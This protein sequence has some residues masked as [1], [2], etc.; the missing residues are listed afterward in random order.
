MTTCMNDMFV[1]VPLADNNCSLSDGSGREDTPASECPLQ[2]GSGPTCVVADTPPTALLQLA[3][4]ATH[5]QS[6]SGPVSEREKET[7]VWLCMI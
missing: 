6:S 1:F 3:E 4:E 5:F 2:L 7:V